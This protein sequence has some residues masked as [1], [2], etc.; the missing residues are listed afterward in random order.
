[1]LTEDYE[2][3][4][5]ACTYLSQSKKDK[6]EEILVVFNKLVINIHRRLDAV[7]GDE[8]LSVTGQNE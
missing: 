6:P 5:V 2:I 1:M 4:N 7:Y 8:A 3:P